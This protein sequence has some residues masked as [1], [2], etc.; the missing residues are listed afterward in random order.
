MWKKIYILASIRELNQQN[1]ISMQ[2]ETPL[3]ILSI[4]ISTL[5]KIKKK[6]MNFFLYLC[7]FVK[8]EFWLMNHFG[9]YD[10]RSLHFTYIE[11][12]SFSIHL[13]KR[14]KRVILCIRFFIQTLTSSYFWVYTNWNIEKYWNERTLYVSFKNGYE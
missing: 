14:M 4:N 11:K 5:S 12:A 3:C 9:K 2:K 10:F 13:W 6:C 7:Q 1:S 8:F